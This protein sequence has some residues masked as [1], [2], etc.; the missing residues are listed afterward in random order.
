M[1]ELSVLARD[2]SDN[3]IDL[4][5]SLVGAYEWT[6]ERRNETEIAAQFAGRWCEMQLWFAW[7]P[8]TRSLFVTCAL[9]MRVPQE[10]R[11]TVYPLLARIN[12]RLWIGHF[13]LW[14]DEGWPTFRHTLIGDGD[15]SVSLGVLEE[16]VDTARVECDRYYPAF[17]F[18]LWG[19][20]DA[21]AAIADSLT[22]P[23]GEA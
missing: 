9:D 2:L 23:E 10:R 18:V 17:Q 19:G 4:V 3:P 11:D 1:A 21:E 14:S 15:M 20:K 6:Y 13:D 12:E 16:V 8:E 5:E 22:E 7:R